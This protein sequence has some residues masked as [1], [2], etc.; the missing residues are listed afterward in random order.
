LG[1]IIK[2]TVFLASMEAFG[3]FNAVYGEEFGAWKPARSVVEASGLPR[4]ALVEIE[5]VAWR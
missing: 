3:E 4:G 5:A 1:A 2:T